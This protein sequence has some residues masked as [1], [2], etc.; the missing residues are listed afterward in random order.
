MRLPF[1]LD[2]VTESEEVA[3]VVPWAGLS[4]LTA[5]PITV[6]TMVPPA[7]LE[8]IPS[9]SEPVTELGPLSPLVAVPYIT[10]PREYRDEKDM[11]FDSRSVSRDGTRVWVEARGVVSSMAEPLLSS[12]MSS[13][14]TLS[15]AL[16]RRLEGNCLAM[17]L[18]AGGGIETLL[19]STFCGP[20]VS[21]SDVRAFR[22]CG[23]VLLLLDSRWGELH[24]RELSAL[25]VRVRGSIGLKEP[26]GGYDNGVAGV[27]FLFF[28]SSLQATPMTRF[29]FSTRSTAA[30]AIMGV[31]WLSRREQCSSKVTIYMS[32]PAA[33]PWRQHDRQSRYYSA[34]CACV[35]ARVANMGR[36]TWATWPDAPFPSC[37]GPAE[38][39]IFQRNEALAWRCTLTIV[40]VMC[41]KA[42]SPLRWASSCDGS[43]AV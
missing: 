2:V 35:T 7:A 31:E 10:D 42:K 3:V 24:E 23:E 25:A 14:I 40:C 43:L 41:S 37:D 15:E 8:S 21:A 5:S 28:F 9:G 6:S 27:A 39:P 11:R 36:A 38:A 4:I 1:W 18:D 32:T 12:S 19:R 33:P 34:H 26:F 13:K 30:H 20:P 17:A 22:F 16:E 29:A